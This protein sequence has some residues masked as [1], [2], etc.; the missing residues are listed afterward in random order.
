MR[1]TTRLALVVAVGA[2][3]A[4][5]GVGTPAVRAVDTDDDLAVVKRAVAQSP[6]AASPAPAATAVPQ[7]T[8]AIPAPPEA[9]KTPEAAPRADKPRWLRIRVVDKAE[10]KSKVSVNVPL[11]LVEAVGDDL[12]IDLH[13]GR[14]HTSSPADRCRIHLSEVLATLKAGQDIVE[15]EDDEG[16]VRIWV[17]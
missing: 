2:A 13:C 8:P 6:P 14:H 16:S 7:A 3:V 11:A 15:V 12:P 17:D 1:T 10:K 9:R 4:A 5:T